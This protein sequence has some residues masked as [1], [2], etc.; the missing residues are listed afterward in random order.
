MSTPTVNGCAIVVPP[1]VTLLS[2]D[3]EGVNPV[4]VVTEAVQLYVVA[5]PEVDKTI[6]VL[7]PLQI[8]VVFVVTE[9][10][11]GIPTGHE[12]MVVGPVEVH[13]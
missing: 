13:P 4:P 10:V 2:P 5:P 12:A 1:A 11:G 9:A 6:F 7:N 8:G 3:T